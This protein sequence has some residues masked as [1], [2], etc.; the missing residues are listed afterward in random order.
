MLSFVAFF[1]E[2]KTLVHLNKSLSL[3]VIH[4]LRQQSWVK[5]LIYII[6]PTTA[7]LYQY[8]VSILLVYDKPHQPD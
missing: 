3:D 5:L 8:S 1:T 6:G 2:E 7:G 4:V